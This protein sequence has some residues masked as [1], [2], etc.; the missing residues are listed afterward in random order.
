VKWKIALKLPEMTIHTPL[1]RCLWQRQTINNTANN[2]LFEIQ[3]FLLLCFLKSLFVDF[4]VQL[5]KKRVKS[6]MYCIQ[7]DWNQWNIFQLTMFLN[8]LLHFKC[9][10]L[11]HASILVAF[12]SKYW[13]SGF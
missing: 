10:I 9:F 12:C 4:S 8:L 1:Y 2:I 11:V 5:H 6:Y 13:S 3:Y 7:G